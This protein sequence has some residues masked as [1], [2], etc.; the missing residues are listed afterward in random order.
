M[1]QATGKAKRLF[2]LFPF[3]LS[4]LSEESKLFDVG[5]VVELLA[6]MVEGLHPPRVLLRIK[7][8]VVE[9]FH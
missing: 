5:V 9:S 4:F 2:L 8:V 1:V 7:V 6:R 3:L